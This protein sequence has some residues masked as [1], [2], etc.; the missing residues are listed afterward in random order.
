MDQTRD[1]SY[2]GLILKIVIAWLSIL[3][4]VGFSVA[5][6][7]TTALVELSVL[8]QVPK[9]GEPIVATFTLNNPS[10]KPLSIDYQFY[11]NSE[12][13]ESGSTVVIPRES[14]VYQYA[15]EN[16]LE[17][18]EQINFVLK[19]N[20]DLGDSEKIFSL[21]AYPSQIMSSFV[22]FAAFSTSVM[23]SMITMEYFTDTFGV[24]EGPNTGII[25]TLVLIGLLIFL[26][27]T[28]AIKTGRGS[29]IISSYRSRFRILSTFLFIIFLGMVFTRIVIILASSG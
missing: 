8:P 10:T 17:R 15:Y 19:T 11:I 5:T 23:T 16:Y 14:S 20:S 9:T 2:K 1:N 12:L 18:G 27:L 28:Q 22:S 26:E 7:S 25:L 6:N 4:L 29:T 3:M 24:S 21:P 13:V